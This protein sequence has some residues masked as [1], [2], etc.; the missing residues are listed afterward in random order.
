MTTIEQQAGA[1]EPDLFADAGERVRA[2]LPEVGLPGPPPPDR[3]A[4]RFLVVVWILVVLLALDRGAT[5]LMDLWLMESL[6]YADVFWTNLWARAVLLVA[7]LALVATAV[8]LP[9]LGAGTPRTRRRALAVGLL[10]GGVAG[11]LLSREYLAFLA[12]R[13]GTPFGETDPV[14]GHDLGFYVF[15]LPALRALWWL[16]LATSVVAALATL[17]AVL[18]RASGSDGSRARIRTSL[19]GPAACV[20][21]AALGLSASTGLFLARYAVL[22]ADNYESSLPS[23]AEHLDVSGPLSTVTYLTV[24]AVVVALVTVAAVILLRRTAR[25]TDPDSDRAHSRVA[26]ALVVVLLLDLVGLGAALA[27]RNLVA[28]EANE[29]VVQ[30]PYIERHLQATRAAW[31]LDDV[32]TAELRPASGT[33]PLPTVDELLASPTMRS[34]GLWP[35]YVSRLERVLDPEYVDR[36]FLGDDDSFDEIYNIT[37]DAFAQQQKLRPYY[38]FLDVDTVRYTVDGE[39]RLYTSAVREVPLLEP[40]PWL[41]WWGQRF[42]LFTHGHGLVGSEV[43][44]A[45]SGRPVFVSSGIPA[46]PADGPLAVANERVYYGEGSGTMAFT[47][48]DR[49]DELDRPTDEGRQETRMPGDSGA[50]VALDSALKRFVFGWRSGELPSILFSAL[51]TDESR[52]HY[53][54]TPLERVRAVAPFLYVDTDPHAVSG[55]ETIT[56]MVN[57]L[58]TATDYPYSAYADLGD[59]SDRRSPTAGDP[60]RVNYAAD[61]VKAT[62][63]AYT[64]RVELYRIDDEPVVETWSRVY[65]GLFRP[66]DDMPDPLREQVQYSTQLFHAQF[67]DLWVYYHVPDALTY[68]NTEDLWDDADEVVGPILGEGAAV[69][70][71][72]EPYPW[73][74][75]T[76][77]ALPGD[78]GGHTFA[79]SMAFTPESAL[80]LR[81]IATAYQDGLDGDYGRLVVLQVPKA[82]F[83]FSPEQAD[84]AIDQD[85]Y[86]S[87]QIGFWNREGNQ[88]IRGHT[89]PLL[90]GDELIYVE[91]IFSRSAQNP[92]PQLQRVVVVVRGRPHIGLDLEDALRVAVEGKEPP[93]L[94]ERAAEVAPRAAAP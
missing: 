45:D 62:V 56:W 64:G 12:W 44:G 94:A 74:A 21:V 9:F 58:T 53:A 28:V 22:T 19:T 70:F 68:F 39:Q 71:S 20:A 88:T 2:Q 51:I 8:I 77:D 48:L 57:G 36:L 93:G 46:G 63:D 34:A 90:V 16:L 92:A 37:L 76:G 31:G 59:K 3:L 30:L 24:S 43:S 73:I 75:P 32:E 80:N 89:T 38:D 7:G 91:P 54:R 66:A 1:A 61:T 49:I 14:F 50:G 79:L 11:W 10:V 60:V 42:V 5:V 86:I 41:T 81:A 27:V 72:M 52:V 83:H 78:P 13:H 25:V 17:V 82:E 15:T 65:P 69:T 87:Q 29:P 40:Q 26:V 23:G 47:N 35:G 84:A 55:G 18:R 67:D 6:G 33:D 85:A 4:G